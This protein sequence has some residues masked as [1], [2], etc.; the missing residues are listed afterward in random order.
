LRTTESAKASRTAAFKIAMIS[1]DVPFG[2]HIP[3]QTAT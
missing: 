3:C 2:A 1:G